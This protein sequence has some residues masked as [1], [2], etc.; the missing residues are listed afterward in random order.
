M[1]EFSLEL[2]TPAT[3]DRY[4][5]ANVI[6][7]LIRNTR[8]KEKY[9]NDMKSGSWKSGTAEMIKISKPV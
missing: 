9:A 5:Q 3:A 4:L 7:R 2:I 8:V 1:I 6:N